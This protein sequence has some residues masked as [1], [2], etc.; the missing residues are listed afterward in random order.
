[1]PNRL[2]CSLEPVK[3]QY[4]LSMCNNAYLHKIDPSITALIMSDTNSEKRGSPLDAFFRLP[5]EIR[6]EIYK[7]I[8]AVP[9]PL[10]IFQ[11]PGTQIECFAPGR[12]YRW[13]SLLYTNRRLS[14]EARAALFRVNSFSLMATPQH[15]TRLLSSFLDCIGSVNAGLLC[16]LILCFP[17]TEIIGHDGFRVREDSLQIFQLLQQ[18]CTSLKI[19]EI[20]IYDESSR[21]LMRQDLESAPSARDTLSEINVQLTKISSLNKIVF[22]LPVT[23]TPSIEDFMQEI[24]WFV[25]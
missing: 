4:T 8:L 2:D 15:P 10:F 24:G 6:D 11:D 9:H 17:G 22:R 19:L 20:F 3:E 1:M 13:R 12:P 16:H 14:N 23:P 5:V 18:K 25:R 21:E 7:L